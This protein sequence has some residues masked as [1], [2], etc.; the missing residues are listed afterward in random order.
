MIQNAHETPAVDETLLYVQGLITGPSS[1]EQYDVQRSLAAIQKVKV[2]RRADRK[3]ATTMGVTGGLFLCIGV[4]MLY[5][6]Y[7]GFGLIT[8]SIGGGA[9]LLAAFSREY[10]LVIRMRNRDYTVHKFD[11][12]YEATQA[13]AVVVRAS[14]S[15]AEAHKSL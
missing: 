14:A 11:S 1:T 4:V 10:W 2:E 3:A 8:S 13:A 6:G 5:L 15:G 12:W 7:W 9:C